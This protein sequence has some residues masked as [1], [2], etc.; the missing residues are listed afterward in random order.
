[1]NAIRFPCRCAIPSAISEAIAAIV[2]NTMNGMRRPSFDVQ[3]SDS[4]PNSGSMNSASMLSSAIIT[5]D[6]LSPM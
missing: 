4:R 5:P 3:R 6:T 1:M 2:P